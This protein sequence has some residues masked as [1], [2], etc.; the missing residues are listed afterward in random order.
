MC[1]HYLNVQISTVPSLRIQGQM[2]CKNDRNPG[3]VCVGR[4]PNSQNA[5]PVAG[6]A[7][8]LNRTVYVQER[9]TSLFDEDAAHFGEFHIPF[10]SC[11]RTDEIYAFFR[12]H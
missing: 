6:G 10:V 3:L 12:S 7:P 5:I 9:R 2:D 11:E 1:S 4:V 8:E